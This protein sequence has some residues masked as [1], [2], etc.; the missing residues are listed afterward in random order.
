MPEK[1]AEELEGCLLNASTHRLR[2]QL[3]RVECLGTGAGEWWP[4]VHKTSYQGL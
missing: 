3:A 2:R 1:L 4:L